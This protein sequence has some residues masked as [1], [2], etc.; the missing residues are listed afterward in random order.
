MSESRPLVE[1]VHVAT[2]EI[3]LCV[4][5]VCGKDI[6]A[7]VEKQTDRQTGEAMSPVSDRPGSTK[8]SNAD[9]QWDVYLNHNCVYVRK[10]GHFLILV[11]SDVFL[12][13]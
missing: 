5:E 12:V 9:L 11:T 1:T 2:L 13:I 8:G 4:G 3:I 7:V 6:H 10:G